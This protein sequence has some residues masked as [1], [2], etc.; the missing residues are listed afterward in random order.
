M[1]RQPRLVIPGLPHHV[2]QRGNNRT[3]MFRGDQDYRF[4]LAALQRAMRKTELAIH[5]YVLMTN[6]VHLIATPK[7]RSALGRAMHSLGH[8]YAT[9]CNKRYAS[10]GGR[11]DGRYRSTVVDT[12]TYLYT[13]MRYVE[14]NPVRAGIVQ[15][16]N[17]YRWSSYRAHAAGE[18][19]ETIAFHTRYLD[20]GTT[21]DERQ[22]CWRAVC[23]EPL[24]ET[25]LAV[26]RKAVH[27][28]GA[29][30]PIRLAVTT[31]SAP[32]TDGMQFLPP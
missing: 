6:H 3:D 17:A 1:A 15:T 19:D 13:C 20:L 22:G 30:G 26:V 7:T 27:C 8:R 29:L 18:V 32:R 5:S 9:Y 24:P 16:P 4:Y 21:P 31:G 2:I 11:F 28:G 25:E 12:D 14:L 23:D 10:S